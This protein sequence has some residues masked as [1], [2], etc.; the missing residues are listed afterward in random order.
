MAAE[1]VS[2][3]KILNTA[4]TEIL[5]LFLN[6]H[7][8]CCALSLLSMENQRLAVQTTINLH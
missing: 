5:K 8:L 7:V 3:E 4:L 1:I 2:K 6:C